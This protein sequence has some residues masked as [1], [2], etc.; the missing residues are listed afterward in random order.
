MGVEVGR[1]SLVALVDAAPNEELRGVRSALDD[2]LQGSPFASY[3]GLRIRQVGSSHV[4]EARLVV[5][6]TR[7]SS[8]GASLSAAELLRA[9]SS[10]EHALLRALPEESVALLVLGGEFGSDLV[11]EWG[12]QPTN[13]LD[14]EMAGDGHWWEVDRSASKVKRMRTITFDDAAAMRAATEAAMGSLLMEG[15]RYR[16]DMTKQRSGHEVV[17]AVMGVPPRGLDVVTS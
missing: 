14:D 1:S 13:C 11:V 16:C 17:A 8:T 6:S 9:S 4:V 5:A 2:A 12:D 10:V 7:V 3:D 15:V